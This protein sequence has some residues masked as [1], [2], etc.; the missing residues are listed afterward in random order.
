MP[1][2]RLRIAL[3]CLLGFT[4]AVSAVG[5]TGSPPMPR[6][7][8]GVDI[9]VGGVFVTPVPNAQFSATVDIV[10]KEKLPDGSFNIRTSVAHIARDAAGRIYNE[11]RALVPSAYKGDPILLSALIYDPA[12]R[13]STFLNPSD[14]LARQ[15]VLPQ[16]RPTEPVIPLL[17]PHAGAAFTKQEDLGEQTVG[18]TL[19]RG[20]RKVWTVPAASSGTGKEV[21]IVDQY[22]Y[23]PDLS[24]YLIIQH[25]D[26]RTGEQIV[27]V[28]DVTRSAPDPSLFVV[29]ARYRIVDE[30]P[31][32]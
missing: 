13:T 14:H 12:T 11:R 19:L 28:K 4:G 21:E 3:L 17:G 1:D 2:G 31:E 29:P 25:D 32:P 16:P 27:A 15:R 9:R 18:T 5:Q 20:T 23:S 24:I 26:P 8:R 7:Y 22:W 30:T 10:S 6:D